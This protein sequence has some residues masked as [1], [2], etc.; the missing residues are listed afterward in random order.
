MLCF[1]FFLSLFL[2]TT[3][4]YSLSW[5]MF[6]QNNTFKKFSHFFNFY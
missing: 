3:L 6:V 2:S 5:L 1:S 4:I